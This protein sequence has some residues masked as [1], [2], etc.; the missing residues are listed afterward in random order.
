MKYVNTKLTKTEHMLSYRVNEQEG[1]PIAGDEPSDRENQVSNR[2]V[3]QV[4]VNSSTVSKLF[5][6]GGGDTTKPNG[7][8]NDT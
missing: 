6:H 8:E 5:R 3:V 4:L 7:A 2:D 1:N